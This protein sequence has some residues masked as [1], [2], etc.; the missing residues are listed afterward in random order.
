MEE[1]QTGTPA[2]LTEPVP[3]DAV[4][5]AGALEVVVFTEIEVVVIA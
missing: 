2:Q 3:V 1:D 5:V 4:V